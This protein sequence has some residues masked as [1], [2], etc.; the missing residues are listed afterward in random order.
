MIP[1]ARL[2]LRPSP[3]A[4]AEFPLDCLRARHTSRLHYSPDRVTPEAAARLAELARGSR[5][6]YAQVTDETRIE[7]LLALNIDA[8]VED[9]NQPLY[10]N[11]LRGW[12]R[13][14]R[15]EAERHGDGLDAGCMNVPPVELWSAFQT[16]SVLRWPLIGRLLRRRYRAQIGPVA[17]MGF[18]CG[19]FWDPAEAY[20]TGRFLLRFWLECTRL[21]YCIHPFGNLVTNRPVAKRVEAE[22]GLADVWL[23]FKIGRSAPPPSSLRR[24]LEEILL[25]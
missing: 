24:K 17:T 19:G 1:F 25:D 11:E 20:P 18:L 13:Y 3:A 9:L 23:A 10:R 15:R 7:K 6:R 12:L 21:G 8:V 5:H 22:T 4:I 14:S 16:P 2:T